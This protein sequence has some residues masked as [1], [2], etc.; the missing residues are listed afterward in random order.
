MRIYPIILITLIFIAC[1]EK[2]QEKAQ[3]ENP[4]E[5]QVTREKVVLPRFPSPAA[6]TEQ[7][8][9]GSN[10]TI[11]YSR[12]SVISPEGIDRSGRIWGILVP[13]DFN[14]RPASL[15]QYWM[16]CLG[17]SLVFFFLENRSSQ[18]APII[19]PSTQ[20]A[21]EELSSPWLSPKITIYLKFS[22]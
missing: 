11:N 2:E 6:I 19:L 3:A 8:I 22:D 14:S 4:I 15:R 9:G 17:K 13:Y 12:P 20:S 7:T 16:A 21:A 18:V 1:T 10:I 5:S